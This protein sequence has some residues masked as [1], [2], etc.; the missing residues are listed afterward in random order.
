MLLWRENTELHISIKYK[1]WI[2]RRNRKAEAVRDEFR[3][4]FFMYTV[5]FVVF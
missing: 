2:R 1:I 4:R 3:E 5:L